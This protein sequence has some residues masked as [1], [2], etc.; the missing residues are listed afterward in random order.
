M[1]VYNNTSDANNNT[2]SILFNSTDYQAL[3]ANNS[4][5]DV[6]N[7]VKSIN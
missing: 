2:E 4:N 1:V 3:N 6:T 5:F 7:L